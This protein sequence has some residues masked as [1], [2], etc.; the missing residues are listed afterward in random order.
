MTGSHARI[1]SELNIQI[2][3]DQLIYTVADEEDEE[4][5]MNKQTDIRIE[6]KQN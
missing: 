1:K 5:Q 4:R 3:S 2:K 6:E